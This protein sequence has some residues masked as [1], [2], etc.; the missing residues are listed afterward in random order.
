MLK[1]PGIDLSDRAL[2]GRA[3][4]D[5]MQVQLDHTLARIATAPD[6]HGR[7]AGQMVADA[8]RRHIKEIERQIILP[9]EVTT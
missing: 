8:L 4:A 9:R 2:A 1:F 7:Q 6:A 3:Q 5:A